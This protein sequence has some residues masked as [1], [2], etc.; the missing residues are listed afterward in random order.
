MPDNTLI[1]FKN[2][3]RE[4]QKALR[5]QFGKQPNGGKAHIIVAIV[6]AAMLVAVTALAIISN[7]M[8]EFNSASIA[9]FLVL[10]LIALRER[11]FS[12]WLEKE[13]GIPRRRLGTRKKKNN[14]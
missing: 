12:K 6:I 9:I 1:I 11:R 13:K 4:E 7:Y 10:L 2:L 3:P 8:V 14:S 5:K